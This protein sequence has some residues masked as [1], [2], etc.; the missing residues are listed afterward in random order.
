MLDSALWHKY[1][2]LMGKKLY[3]L[4]LNELMTKLIAAIE[5]Y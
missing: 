2:I 4:G 3:E 1:C 5:N